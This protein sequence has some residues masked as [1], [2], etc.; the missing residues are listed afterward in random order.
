MG[1]LTIRNLDDTVRQRLR[2]RAAA[3]GV[4]MEEEARTILGDAVADAGKG[5]SLESFMASVDRLKAR[6]GPFALDVPPR[7]QAVWE[8]PRFA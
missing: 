3:R 2:E 8:P 6:Y 4:S 5:A 7:S 1:T